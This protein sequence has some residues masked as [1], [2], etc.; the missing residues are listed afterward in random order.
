VPV[1]PAQINFRRSL[2]V[3]MHDDNK[4]LTRVRTVSDFIFNEVHKN[5]SMFCP[6]AAFNRS[7]RAVTGNPLSSHRVLNFYETRPQQR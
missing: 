7:E 3:L 4:T 1:L 2:Y 5:R 6:E